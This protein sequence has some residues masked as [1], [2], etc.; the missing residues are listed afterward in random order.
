MPHWALCLVSFHWSFLK[1]ADKED[2]D[3]ILDELKKKTGYIG[4]V[5]LDFCPLDC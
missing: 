3:K 4:S 2:I 5:I 1:L